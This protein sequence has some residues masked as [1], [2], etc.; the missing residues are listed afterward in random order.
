MYN[1]QIFRNYFVIIYCNL[2][3][4][5]SQ[6]NKCIIFEPNEL[7]ITL[8]TLWC[9]PLQ[10]AAHE[11]TEEFE[12]A[13]PSCCSWTQSART[14]SSRDLLRYTSPSHSASA[15]LASLI[16]YFEECHVSKIT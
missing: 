12:E 2:T 11:H 3:K 15:T 13:S 9:D 10:L 5:S 1:N 4:A 7:S 6:I 14:R 16:P 8:S